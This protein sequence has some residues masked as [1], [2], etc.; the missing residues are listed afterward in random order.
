MLVVL[1]GVARSSTKRKVMP[2]LARSVSLDSRVQTP[3]ILPGSCTSLQ[4]QHASRHRNLGWL[5]G[6]EPTTLGTTNRCSNQLSYS[7]RSAE[8]IA[9]AKRTVKPNR[10]KSSA[11]ASASEFSTSQASPCAARISACLRGGSYRRKRNFWR[12]NAGLVSEKGVYLSEKV[13][14]T[15]RRCPKRKGD[16]LS[17]SDA[18]RNKALLQDSAILVR[19]YAHKKKRKE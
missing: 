11:L 1:A 4:L 16:L 2:C 12:T 13:W 18:T 8:S 6:L 14:I 9:C 19:R 5:M 10:A 15:S 7:H 17:M 3:H